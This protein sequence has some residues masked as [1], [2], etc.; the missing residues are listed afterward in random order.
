MSFIPYDLNEKRLKEIQLEGLK[1]TVAHVYKNS[2]FYKE[3]LENASIKPEDIRSLE[4]IKHLP[5]ID[6][7]DLEKEYYRWFIKCDY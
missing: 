5:F 3:K 7:H 6:T 1:W 4:H 2:P